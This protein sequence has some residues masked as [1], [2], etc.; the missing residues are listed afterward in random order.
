MPL[1][2][3][4]SEPIGENTATLPRSAARSTGS[5]S[6]G[7][8]GS[9]RSSIR[10]SRNSTSICRSPSQ[11][12]SSSSRNWPMWQGNGS[13]PS[14]SKTGTLARNCSSNVT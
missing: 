14:A 13:M 10:N 4:S 1:L 12:E 3:Y 9:S 6:S 11:M 8:A 7:P 5:I 2:L